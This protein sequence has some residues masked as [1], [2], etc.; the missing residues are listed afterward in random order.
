MDLGP[1]KPSGRPMM[2]WVTRSIETPVIGMTSNRECHAG[3]LGSAEFLAVAAR[4]V[5]VI[6]WA[7]VLMAEAASAQSWS[8]LAPSGTLPPTRYAQCQIYNPKSGNMTIFGGFVGP[9]NPYANDVWVLSGANGIGTPSWTQLSA[10]GVGAPGSP[11]GRN[12]ASCVYDS[13]NNRMIM[14]GGEANFGGPSDVEQGDVWVLTN[15]DGTGG[16]SQWIQLQPTGAIQPRAGHGAFY[17]PSSNRMIVYLG[18]TVAN[19]K[20]VDVWALTNANGLGGTPA[21]IQLS[22][23]GTPP[24]GRFLNPI[25]SSWDAIENRVV[26]FG[27][28]PGRPNDRATFNDTWVLTNANGLGGTPTWIQLSPQGALPPPRLGASGFYDSVTKRLIVFG[29][30]TDPGT[31]PVLG[32]LWAL[33]NADGNGTTVWQQISPT[34]T[35]IPGRSLQGSVYDINLNRMTVFGGQLIAAG[36]P[37]NETWILTTANGISGSQLQISSITPNH[38]GN[39]G[40]VS[41]TI[42]GTGFRS[43]ALITLNGVGPDILAAN[44][45]VIDSGLLTVSFDLAGSSAVPGVRNVVFTNP[46]KSTASLPSGFT[47][48]Q[49]GGPQ[50]WTRLNGRTVT[51]IGFAQTFFIEYGNLGNTDAFGTHVLAYF[52]SAVAP[53]LTFGNA[54]GVV[55]RLAQG[56]TTIV[57]IDVGRVKAGSISLIPVTLTASASQTPFQIQVHISG[58]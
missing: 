13:A 44:V 41:A 11:V 30:T 56:A 2:H 33:S 32:D 19:G 47:V 52:P 3:H 55:A 20:F 43:G 27:G 50:L 24:A 42:T 6:L 57:M 9:G 12:S 7:G 17:D 16:P 48:D 8:Q 39:A 25:D 37:V 40:V 10:G 35:P 38:G 14:F 18:G 1:D 34:G 54:N 4:F 5:T 29:G 31:L 53:N 51:R 28:T 58:H 15:A 45:N 23:T 21:W 26:L 36:A 46:D 22:T 49:G